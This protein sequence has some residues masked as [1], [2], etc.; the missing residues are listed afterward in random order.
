MCSPAQVGHV[1]TG[2]DDHRT[3]VMRHGLR[4]RIAELWADFVGDE[5]QDEPAT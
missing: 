3:A 4:H 2:N 1:G 5:I